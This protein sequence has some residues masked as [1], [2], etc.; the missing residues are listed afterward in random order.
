MPV[1]GVIL[2]KPTPTTCII[3]RSGE[4]ST[5]VGLVVGSNY[6]ADTAAGLITLTPPVGTGRVVQQVGY[7][8]TV[9]TLVIELKPLLVR[10]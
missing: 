9:T 6:F 2:S 4:V 3:A 7:A 10:A 8:K 5:F 1:I